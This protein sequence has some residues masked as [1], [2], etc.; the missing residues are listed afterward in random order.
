MSRQWLLR[1][2]RRVTAGRGSSSRLKYFLARQLGRGRVETGT[3]RTSYSLHSSSVAEIEMIG[4]GGG[5][6]RGTRGECWGQRWPVYRGGKAR[7]HC[8]WWLSWCPHHCCPWLVPRPAAAQPPH[9]GR[10][11]SPG[12]AWQPSLGRP[13][14]QISQGISQGSRQGHAGSRYSSPAA[15]SRD[16]YIIIAGRGAVLGRGHLITGTQ[17]GPPQP[18]PGWCMKIRAWL[19]VTLVTLCHVLW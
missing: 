14:L 7:G 6:W 8:T 15:A 5:R 17:L 10:C 13:V 9:T 18:D 2:G 1:R 3:G 19:R 11:N 16:N 12:R 4:G